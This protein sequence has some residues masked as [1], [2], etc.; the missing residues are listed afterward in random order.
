[1]STAGSKTSKTKRKRMAINSKSS[2]FNCKKLKAEHPK[3]R[4]SD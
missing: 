1:M 4:Q 2:K 3:A